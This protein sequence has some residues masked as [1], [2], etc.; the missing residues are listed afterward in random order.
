MFNKFDMVNKSVSERRPR[1]PFSFLTLS[2]VFPL[3]VEL[4]RQK[5]KNSEAVNCISVISLAGKEVP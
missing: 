2:N 1:L 3:S 5:H 4:C